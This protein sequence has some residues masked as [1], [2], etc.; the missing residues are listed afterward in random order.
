[1]SGLQADGRAGRRWQGLLVSVRAAA[2]ASDAL[3]GGAAIIDVKEPAR[4]PLGPANADAAAAVAA[5]IGSAAAW[6]LACGELAAGDA[7]AWAVRACVAVGALPAAA[8]AGP[9]GLSLREWRRA[10]T[11]FAAGLPAGVESV[12]VAYADWQRTAAPDPH[13]VITAAAGIGCRTLLLDTGDKSGP[14]LFGSAGSATVAGWIT[15]AHAAGMAVAAAGRLTL[16]EIAQARGIG[17]DVVAVRGAVCRGGRSGVVD[18]NLVREAS[19]LLELAVG[20]G[21]A[22]PGATP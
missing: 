13:A 16:E 21:H 4:G 12:A 8:K 22:V 20:L 2:E 5:T 7:A 15:A 1:M 10:F 17:A 9:A 3:A 11:A 6:T 14:G 18:R 19:T